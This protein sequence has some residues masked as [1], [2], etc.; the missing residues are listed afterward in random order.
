M[1]VV[2]TTERINGVKYA[3]VLLT[4][5]KQQLSWQQKQAQMWVTFKAI[6]ICCD[7]RCMEQNVVA[8]TISVTSL[9]RGVGKMYKTHAP[10][11]KSKSRHT[12]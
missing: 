5:H 7:S 6:W 10:Q 12:N 11:E 1:K 3:I 8:Y 2:E 9:Q 4:V